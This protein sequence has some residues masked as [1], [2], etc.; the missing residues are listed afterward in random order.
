MNKVPSTMCGAFTV[1]KTYIY[2]I[3]FPEQA[4]F[5]RYMVADY[6]AQMSPK[7]VALLDGEPIF[8]HLDSF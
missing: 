5:D 3:S 1:P 2:Y 7:V 4:A 8:E 6:H